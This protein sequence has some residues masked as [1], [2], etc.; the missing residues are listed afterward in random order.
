MA[1]R[2][3]IICMYM[4]LGTSITRAQTITLDYYFNHKMHTAKNGQQQQF[5]YT[6]E[7]S[8]NTGFSIWGNIF[9]NYGATLHALNIA[10]TA[11]NLKNTS[12]Y[13]ITDPDNLKANPHP[14]YISS[15]DANEVAQWVKA[16]G[17]LVLMGNDSAH[18]D[19]PHFN[20][21]AGK[22]GLHFNN[23]LQ[24]HV[25]DDAHFNDGQAVIADSSVLQSAKK[26]F[27]K[28]VCSISSS[29]QAKIVLRSAGN[30]AAI[31]VIT[32]YGK[33]TVF[34][35]GDPWLYNEYVNGRLPAD[36]ENDR[37][38]ADLAGWLIDEAKNNTN[39][40]KPKAEIL[41]LIDKNLADADAQYHLLIRY[42]PTD[43]LPETFEKSHWK[44][45]PSSWW[46]SGFSPG[47]M[48]YLYEATN[49]TTL[50][51]DALR[52]LKVM[53]PEQNNNSHDVGFMMNDSYGLANQ[54][55]PNAAY[56]Q[57]LINS[58]NTL[59]KRFNK[60]VGCTLSWASP[61][62]QFK[63]IIDNMMNLELLMWASKTTGDSSYAK[64]AISHANTT[65]KN[66]FRADYSSWHLVIYD[67][68]T[69]RVIK[70]QTVQGTA[71]SSAWARG[72]AWG[73]YGY[74]MMYRETHNPQYLAQANHIANF[75]LSNPA[76]PADGIPYWDFN[77]PNIPNAYRDASAGAIYA[78]ALIELSHYTDTADAKKYIAAA[79][80]VIKTLSTPQFKA[81]NGSNGGFILMHSVG[82]LPA[83]SLIDVPLTYAD[84]YF[85]EAMLRYKNLTALH[86]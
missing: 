10:P 11:Q 70:K 21:L 66:H 78:S 46:T 27:L 56:R 1:N 4:L 79:E 61:P 63:V 16:G 26:V 55:A 51:H 72:Q 52:K 25:V 13:I 82:N 59:A 85:V 47:T 14:N 74:T 5:H 12:I 43:S 84:Y 9:K 42:V 80:K 81:K 86:L 7:D 69:G 32:K 49:D 24:N 30:T 37:A 53:E 64:I 73:L 65:M 8:E 20:I 6:W 62:G 71:D 19:L 76:L 45:M 68:E 67:A 41:K 36:F 31:A 54:I 75:I 77:A 35:V 28:D 2:L 3:L 34:A 83:K 17:V 60:N 44:S 33:G 18:V 23:D 57:I 58:A 48:F 50:Y 15:A 38:A 29:S 39:P 40:V 22:F